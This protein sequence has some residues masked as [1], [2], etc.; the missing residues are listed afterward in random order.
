MEFME[1][2]GRK[3]RRVQPYHLQMQISILLRGMRV[4]FDACTESKIL[5]MI[6]HDSAV[7]NGA[8]KGVRQV[9]AFRRT[10]TIRMDSD[11]EWKPVGRRSVVKNSSIAR[12][13]PF[14]QWVKESTLNMFKWISYYIQA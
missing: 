14:L 11:V 7:P 5:L 12:C 10:T 3:D 1:E 9:A 2:Y 4:R 13:L 6:D 8:M